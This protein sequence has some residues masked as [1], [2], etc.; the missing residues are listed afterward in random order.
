M[1]TSNQ[2]ISEPKIVGDFKVYSIS[3]T[4]FEVPKHYT[5]LKFLGL[6]A[7]GLA[8]SCLDTNTKNKVCI[9]KC[10]DILRDEEDGKRVLR[11]IAM[12][13]FFKHENLLSVL[14][15]LPPLNKNYES[16]KDIYVVTPL[17]DVD[18]NV[19][20]RSRQGLEESHKQYFV[21]QI[22][23]GLKYLHSANVAHRDLKPAN[24]VT[25]ISCDLK[26]IDFGLSRSV[27]VPFSDLT[28][29]VITR[30]YR[31][32]ELLLENTNYTTA[33]DIWSVGCV[34]AELYNRKPIFPGRNTMDQLRL[35]CENVGKPPEDCVERKEALEKLRDM[36]SGQLNV[37]TLVP[38]LKGNA[39]GIDFLTQMLELDPR[40]R[41][42]AEKMLAHP[43]LASLH[44][45][46]DEPTC[47][48]TFEWPYEKMTMQVADLRRAF[49]K[50]I[51]HYNPQFADV[52]PPRRH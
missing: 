35:I 3:G 44:D 6:G 17:M 34:F 23:R 39:N 22:L 19:V 47:S 29:Y 51:I 4:H 15:I 11:E 1:H 8:C 5:V 45:E 30:W 41:P 9:K 7:Y 36:P 16:L 38:G 24:L 10:R 52:L 18:L 28:D 42:T 43:F 12:M 25:N 37:A 50:D 40:R 20:L 27:E 13:R 31:P 33:V 46:S 49:W 2:E 48:G 26:I 32:P 21:Y 14:T